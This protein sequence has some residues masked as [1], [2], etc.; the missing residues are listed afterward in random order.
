MQTIYRKLLGKWRKI[1]AMLQ[2]PYSYSADFRLRFV[3]LRDN[4]AASDWSNILAHIE[5]FPGIVSLT[6]IEILQVPTEGP[7]LLRVEMWS[8]TKL[9]LRKELT[10][11]EL[12]LLA[13]RGGGS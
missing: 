9:I 13:S 3:V 5:L 8:G 2:S 12:S 1:E 6:P 4:L 7:N 10:Q 11:V